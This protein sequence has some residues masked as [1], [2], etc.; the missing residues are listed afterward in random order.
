MGKNSGIIPMGFVYHF[1]LWIKIS[2]KLG[3]LLRTHVLWAVKCDFC[4]QYHSYVYPWL[5]LKTFDFQWK[6]VKLLKSF[7]H[8]LKEYPTFLNFNKESK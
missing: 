5:F 2:H 3:K 7:E 8:T 1:G 6:I 4:G